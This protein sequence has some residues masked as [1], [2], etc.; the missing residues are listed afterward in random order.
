MKS[1]T[2]SLP[3][4]LN[5]DSIQ[6]ESISKDLSKLTTEEVLD[7]IKKDSPELLGMLTEMKTK[8][9]DVRKN[10]LPLLEKYGPTN[11]HCVLNCYYYFF[12]TE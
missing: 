10:L 2:R 11:Y 12:I 8:A 1:T 4:L 5:F 9:A 6:V 7:I 3:P